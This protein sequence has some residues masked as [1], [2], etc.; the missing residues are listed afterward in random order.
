VLWWRRILVLWLLLLLLRWSEVLRLA[1][2]RVVV[3][4]GVGRR[5]R[6]ML[7]FFGMF[8]RFGLCCCLNAIFLYLDWVEELY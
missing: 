3:L 7:L 6:V 2:W 1:W 8:I 5:R 4:L